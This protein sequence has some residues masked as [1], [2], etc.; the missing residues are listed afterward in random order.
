MLNNQLATF[1]YF[2]TVIMRKS[3]Y[4]FSC[5]IDNIFF[6]FILLFRLL[7][8]MVTSPMA[9]NF[10]DETSTITVKFEHV[11]EARSQY[12]FTNMCR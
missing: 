5:L 12:S 10:L 3:W 8:V 4:K 1:V 2:V 9:V 7:D 6:P 11:H